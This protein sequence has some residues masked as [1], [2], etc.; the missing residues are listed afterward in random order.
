MTHT[1]P[2]TIYTWEKC[3]WCKSAKELL[4]QKRIE[5][6][7]REVA[8]KNNYNEIS[9]YL[10]AKGISKVTVP[11]IFIGNEHIGGYGD[12]EK[13]NAEN[14]LDE[15][16]QDDSFYAIY[17]NNLSEFDESDTELHTSN[18]DDIL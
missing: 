7:E 11:Q 16:L 10:N 12:L 15:M 17:E 5:Y 1:K 2:V 6:E 8:D 9:E 18:G 13:L 4:N 14:K 3:G